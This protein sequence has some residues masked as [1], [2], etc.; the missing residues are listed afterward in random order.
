IRVRLDGEAERRA[1]ELVRLI[2]AKP[3]STSVRLR[4]EKPRDFVVLLDIPER[5][6]PDREFRVELERICGPDACES[7]D[8]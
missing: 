4:L 7:L 1:E 3:G 5:I 6:R 8:S 2:R